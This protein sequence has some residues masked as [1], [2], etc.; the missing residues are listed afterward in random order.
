MLM[1]LNDHSA[2]T[3]T[4]ISKEILGPLLASLIQGVECTTRGDYGP[5]NYSNTIGA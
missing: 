3:K 2:I 5:W 1:S 4:G